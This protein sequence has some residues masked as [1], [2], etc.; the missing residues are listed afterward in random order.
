MWRIRLPI[1]VAALLVFAAGAAVVQFLPRLYVAQAV[2]APAE[3]TGI[4]TSTLLSPAPMLGGGLLESRQTGHFA[5]YLDVLRSPEAVAVLARETGL[6][7]YLTAL[8]GSGPGG[9]LRRLLDLRIEADLDD[10]QNWVERNLAITP[11]IGTVTVT[12]SLAHQDRAAALDAL[13]RLHALAEAKVRADLAELTHRRIAA[14]EARLAVETDL[15]LRNM[16]YDQLG[17]HQRSGLI[18]GVDE[19][20]AAR[21]VSRPMVELRP[22]LPNRPL[23]LL[24]LA[25]A[26]PVLALFGAA[27]VVLLGGAVPRRRQAELPFGFAGH[28]GGAD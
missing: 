19:A 23:L 28:R 18:I 4:A 5:V 7:A 1:V 3:T 22:S 27:C 13:Q 11:G 14:I 25:V 26:A 8:R 6:L 20:V 16:L 2:V 10:A 21:L 17:Q 15:F 9:A 24:L 12:L